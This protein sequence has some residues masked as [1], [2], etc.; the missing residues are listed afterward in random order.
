MKTTTDRTATAMA[1]VDTENLNRAWKSA[2]PV[3]VMD[4]VYWAEHYGDDVL[5]ELRYLPTVHPDNDAWYTEQIRLT[6]RIA[7]HFG[8]R[9]LAGVGPSGPT[10]PHKPTRLYSWMADGTLCV[11]CCDCGA[12]LKGAL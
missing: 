9:A 5:A 12:V 4:L 1:T 7:A 10:C 2:R 11:C 8:R 6:A 3:T